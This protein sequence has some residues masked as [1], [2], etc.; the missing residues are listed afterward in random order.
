MILDIGMLI[1]TIINI[2]ILIIDSSYTYLLRIDYITNIYYLDILNKHILFIDLC[3]ISI[4]LVELIFKF[5]VTRKEYNRWWIF[6]LFKWYDIISLIPISN[7]KIL[8]LIRIVSL[9]IKLNKLNKINIKEFYLYKQYELLK[10][11]V[12]EELTDAMLIN[13]LNRTNKKIGGNKTNSY[14][15]GLPARAGTS[16][17]NR[18]ISKISEKNWKK[19]IDD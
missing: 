9:I 19:L 3:F 6:F 17:I 2:L 1:I 4:Y 7:F 13:L 5:F 8:R 18:L 16:I 15:F 14:V 12:L 11:I 10:N